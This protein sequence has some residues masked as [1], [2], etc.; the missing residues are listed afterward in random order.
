[1]KRLK[2]GLWLGA[3]FFVLLLA[4]AGSWIYYK[5]YVTSDFALSHA[6]AFLFR[7]MTVAQLAEQG[8][9]RY[10]Y[11]TNRRQEISEGPIVILLAGRSVEQDVARNR[12]AQDGPGGSELEPAVPVFRRSLP[13]ADPRRGPSGHGRSV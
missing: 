4:G 10:F 3:A 6:E 7:R 2:R 1:M 11:I 5:I 8:T 12:P 9:Y 13:G